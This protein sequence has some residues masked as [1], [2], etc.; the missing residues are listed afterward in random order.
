MPDLSA[1]TGLIA[2]FRAA[3]D[4]TRGLLELKSVSEVQGK[5]IELQ[6]VIMSAQN[7]AMTAQTDLAAAL[8]RIEA[9][10]K[11]L[12]SVQGWER[13]KRRYDLQPIYKD[14]FAY[15]LRPEAQGQEPPHWLCASCFNQDKKSI[16]QLVTESSG[17][18]TYECPRCK[19]RL[20]VGEWNP[21]PIEYPS[22][23][24]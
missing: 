5:V 22:N 15:V 12:G 24:Y 18:R 13:E 3:S 16:L 2:S 1:I 17:Q 23:P 10:E 21:P 4:I 14:R 20:Q 11:E 6:S 8:Q 19:A 9:L 7:A